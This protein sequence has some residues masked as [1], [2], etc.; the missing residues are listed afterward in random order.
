[1]KVESF[2]TGQAKVRGKNRVTMSIKM[3]NHE[4][5]GYK[6]LSIEIKDDCLLI[7][8]EEK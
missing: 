8:I 1:M 2:L 5:I 6:P 3:K 7:L 4:L